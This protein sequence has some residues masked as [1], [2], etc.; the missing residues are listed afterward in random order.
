MVG[1]DGAV[2]ARASVAEGESKHRALDIGRV[3]NSAIVKVPRDVGSRAVDVKGVGYIEYLIIG[4]GHL[5]KASRAGRATETGAGQNASLVGEAGDLAGIH[6]QVHLVGSLR[7]ER[8][9]RDVANAHRLCRG[10]IGIRGDEL[11]EKH[12]NRIT[13]GIGPIAYIYFDERTVGV[14][15][16]DGKVATALHGT[17]VCALAIAANEKSRIAS[18]SDFIAISILSHLGNGDGGV[19]I[20]VCGGD[21]RSGEGKS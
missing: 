4:P 3:R 12:G 21:S 14:H 20:D 19:L 9:T 15:L 2:K 10:A 16:C 7:G 8:A 1:T 17:T 6:G 13:I 18:D 11:I 5:H